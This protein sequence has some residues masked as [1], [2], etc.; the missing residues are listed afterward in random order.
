PAAVPDPNDPYASISDEDL[1]TQAGSAL[2]HA[3]DA[4][5]SSRQE[6]GFAVAQY[7]DDSADSFTKAVEA[8]KAKVGEAFALKQKLDDEVPDSSEQRRT[9]HI[10]IIQL[11]DEAD[12]LLN[13]N[14]EAF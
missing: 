5:T 9:W 3:D 14:I 8:A 2:V 6:L 7:G 4:I 11:C 12:D 13:D 10:Q 1:E